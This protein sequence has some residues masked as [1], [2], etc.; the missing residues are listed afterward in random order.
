MLLL[1]WLLPFFR[2]TCSVLSSCTLVG[3]P[4]PKLHGHIRKMTPCPPQT[5]R[6]LIGP[7]A[8][9]RS[10]LASSFLAP[11][12]PETSSHCELETGSHCELLTG[13]SFAAKPGPPQK[14]LAIR[15]RFVFGSEPVL[16]TFF[17]KG[18]PSHL[19]LRLFHGQVVADTYGTVFCTPPE[20]PPVLKK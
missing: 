7:L 4:W 10:C 12:E 13:F 8:S 5:D 15:A 11:G 19:G 6:T 9:K 1:P 20:P 16:K 18:W 3:N 14:Q 2:Y 17:C